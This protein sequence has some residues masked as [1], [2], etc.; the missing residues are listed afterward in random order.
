MRNVSLKTSVGAASLALCFMSGS[1]WAQTVATATAG[2]SNLAV[3]VTDLTP[4][5]GK[6]A[7]FSW[8]AGNPGMYVADGPLYGYGSMYASEASENLPYTLNRTSLMWG[9][10][11]PKA[12]DS[13]GLPTSNFD[14]IGYN[15]KSRASG[16]T[17]GDLKIVGSQQAADAN[18]NIKQ[19]IAVA[20]YKVYGND[21]VY[22]EIYNSYPSGGNPE[23]ANFSLS[24]H[25]SVTVSAKF[26][27]ETGL[28]VS[29]LDPSLL[30]QIY[31]A[32]FALG[33]LANL[34]A[35]GTGLTFSTSS[36]PGSK[37]AYAH[38][39]RDLLMLADG[40]VSFLGARLNGQAVATDPGELLSRDAWITITNNTTGDLTGTLTYGG[41]IATIMST[42][43]PEPSTYALMGLGLVGLSVVARQRRAKRV[44]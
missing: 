26:L 39:E 9:S 37:V 32:Q 13:T 36:G 10:V 14:N 31:G 43:V 38:V 3:K 7:G 35:T 6:A 41:H 33:S 18:D 30:S 23:K 28:D 24:A 29:G 44:H 12:F 40:S 20:G 11:F 19:N 4:N 5:D 1:A 2:I 16:S 27:L 34:Y 22:A 25:S 8:L 42:S 21:G 17:L 15:N